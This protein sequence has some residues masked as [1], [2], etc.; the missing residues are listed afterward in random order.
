MHAGI[1]AT[2]L[3]EGAI[4]NPTSEAVNAAIAILENFSGI[5]LP[6]LTDMHPTLRLGLHAGKIRSNSPNSPASFLN[7]KAGTS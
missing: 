6:G 2:V 1:L 5:F 3:Q 7:V 4:S